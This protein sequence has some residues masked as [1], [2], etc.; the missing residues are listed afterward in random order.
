MLSHGY[1]TV[2]LHA[3]GRETHRVKRRDVIE[4]TKTVNNDDSHAV[5]SVQ[6]AT[7]CGDSATFLQQRVLMRNLLLTTRIREAIAETGKRS[8][9]LA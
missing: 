5:P 1:F 6:K 4:A 7:R 2:F 3:Y 8:F 9:R